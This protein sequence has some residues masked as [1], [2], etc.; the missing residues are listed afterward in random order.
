MQKVFDGHNDLLLRLWMEN[1]RNGKLFFYGGESANQNTLRMANNLKIGKLGHIDLPRAKLGGYIGGFFAVFVP[2]KNTY[3]LNEKDSPFIKKPNILSKQRYALKSTIEMINI[4]WSMNELK[5]DIIKVILSKKD[6]ESILNLNTD[7]RINILL[8]LE[9][10]EAI[11][12]ELLELDQLFHLGLRSL[13]PVWSRPNIFGFGVPF[14][15][16]SSPNIGPGLTDIGKRL[17]KEC[18]KKGIMIDLSHMNEA[19]FWDTAKISSKPL[20]ATHS[21]VHQLSPS[22][23]NLTEKQLD[24]IAESKGVVGL[25]FA[26]MF[27]RQDGTTNLNTEQNIILKHFDHLIEKLGE[28]GVAIGSDFDG[29]PIPKFIGDCSG[30]PNL[31]DSML[32]ADY[33]KSLINKI[34]YK[35]W[36]DVLHRTIE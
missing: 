4:V 21:N 17:I 27:L 31:I 6:L 24:A 26:T 10:A 8:H 20:V 28:N 7:H 23:R 19:G 2:D 13:G 22:P 11:G 16:P 34:C 18:N 9:G 14:N 32:K 36:H 1:D 15:F 30:L 29:A 3:N 25:N 12:K 33:G 35:N 5:P